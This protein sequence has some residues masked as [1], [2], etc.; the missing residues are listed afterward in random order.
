MS[1]GC[2]GA[3]AILCPCVERQVVMS[4]LEVSH[5]YLDTGNGYNGLTVAP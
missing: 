5:V 3:A 1:W 4:L 2:L